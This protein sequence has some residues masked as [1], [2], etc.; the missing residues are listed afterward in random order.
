MRL[1]LLALLLCCAPAQ[2]ALPLSRL[3]LPQ[4]GAGQGSAGQ[5]ASLLTRVNRSTLSRVTGLQF[6]GP[7]TA[8]QLLPLAA[9][10]SSE[11]RAELRSVLISAD[12]FELF[13]KLAAEASTKAQMQARQT[14]YRLV[15]DVDSGRLQDGSLED[16]EAFSAVFP[17]MY[18][19]YLADQEQA[20][21]LL[22]SAKLQLRRDV[23]RARRL[24]AFDAAMKKHVEL[25]QGAFASVDPDFDA[26]GDVI[27]DLGAVGIDA[28][29]EE[30]KAAAR[31]A[32]KI[33]ESALELSW[34]HGQGSLASPYGPRLELLNEE[35]LG[36]TDDPAFKRELN[37]LHNGLLK[38]LSVLGS[39][40]FPP[41]PAKALA[42][43]SLREDVDVKQARA[44]LKTAKF[45]DRLGED[46]AALR[47]IA[48]GDD[49]KWHSFYALKAYLD[50][51]SDRGVS[52]DLAAKLSVSAVAD[53]ISGAVSAAFVVIGLVLAVAQGLFAL[54]PFIALLAL[55]ALL[56]LWSSAST[57]DLVREYGNLRGRWARLAEKLEAANL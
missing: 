56:K 33:L 7:L 26:V 51:M 41:V 44:L 34:S 46:P 20:E 40:A 12:R 36:L 6:R 2:A 43:L 16:F 17:Q 28:T 9:A 49:G 30:K 37:R 45:Y 52:R 14:V 32:Y 13:S 11:Q 3:Y 27:S 15:S 5:V 54:Y 19:P 31:N 21:F 39:P 18:G 1:L 48:A 42:S 25:F 23:I 47:R 53:S 38:R 8:A 50:A 57:H 24:A 10:L 22:A 29:L 4:A 55:A 35:A